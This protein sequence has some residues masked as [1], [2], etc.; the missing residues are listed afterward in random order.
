MS[1]VIKEEVLDRKSRDSG[2]AIE[3][4]GGGIKELK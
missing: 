1:V 4:K 3:E 2:H